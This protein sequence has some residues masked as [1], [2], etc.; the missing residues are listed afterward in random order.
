MVN[1][2]SGVVN[3]AD[4]FLIGTL[5]QIVGSR[6]HNRILEMNCNGKSCYDP[7]DYAR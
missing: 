5:A 3:H 7:T 1:S 2:P 6:D 4:G